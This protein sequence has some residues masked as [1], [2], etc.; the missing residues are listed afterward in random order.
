MTNWAIANAGKTITQLNQIQL[1]GS[2]LYGEYLGH[3]CSHG[4]QG[5]LCGSCQ[6]DH[7]HSGH[8]C[9]KCL[10]PRLNGFVYFLLCCFMFFIPVASMWLHSKNVAKRTHQIHEAER[11]VAQASAM[12]PA[13]VEQLPSEPGKDVTPLADQQPPQVPAAP[14]VRAQDRHVSLM[15][16]SPFSAVIEN[17]NAGP[18]PVQS[19]P[20][21]AGLGRSRSTMPMRSQPGSAAGF[22]G[23]L[24]SVEVLDEEL[25]Q[26]W[27][28]SISSAKPSTPSMKDPAPGKDSNGLQ[29][30]LPA[31]PPGPP[32]LSQGSISPPTAG[33]MGSFKRGA[34]RTHRAEPA[35]P[36]LPRRRAFKFWHTDVIMV[37]GRLLNAASTAVDVM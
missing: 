4:Y 9:M 21:S 27:A 7:G 22:L 6:A 14:H 16:D 37:S 15:A 5:A 20:S 31:A 25:V 32:P 29:A 28:I 12:Q 24:F 26:P 18:G 23:Q 35:P 33:R 2:P 10:S 3:M 1:D 17:S 19:S 13:I 11:L 34:S 8:T 30:P 36:S